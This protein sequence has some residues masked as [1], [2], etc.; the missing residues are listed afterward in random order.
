MLVALLGAAAAG[1]IAGPGARLFDRRVGLVAG[2]LFAVAFLP[3][4]YAHFAVNDVPALAP[5]CLSLAGAAGVYRHGRL[6][7]YALAGAALGVAC[8]TKYTAGIVLLCLLGA[9]ATAPNRLRGLALAGG[10]RGRRLRGR[11]TRTRCST[12][13]RSATGCG[14]SRR[15]R[16]T[17]AAS[18]VWWGTAASSTTSAP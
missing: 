4:H 5:L 1:L 2:A 13:T 11:R 15:R 16:A 3:V 9:A 17:A 6:R 12:S 10:L 7:D 14:C 8:A 18:S